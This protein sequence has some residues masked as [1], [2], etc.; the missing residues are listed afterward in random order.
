MRNFVLVPLQA[1]AGEMLLFDEPSDI[2]LDRVLRP[3]SLTRDLS[4][5]SAKSRLALGTNKLIKQIETQIA[6]HLFALCV[7]WGRV[8]SHKR[9][10][11]ARLSPA[12]SPLP[13]AGEVAV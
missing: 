12:E 3:A 4:L 13:L 5:R 11:K 1:E 8:S 9:L 7:F 10:Q 6:I 2:R